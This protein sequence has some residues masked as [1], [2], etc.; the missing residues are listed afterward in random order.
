MKRFLK[1]FIYLLSIHCSALIITSAL[2]VILFVT[3]H[4]Q[5]STAA[6]ADRNLQITAFIRGVWFDNVIGCYAL[7]L[8]LVVAVITAIFN[9]YKK[10]LFRFYYRVFQYILC[11][12]IPN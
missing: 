7:A 3:L 12:S 11:D 6:L 4:H 1:L 2:R 9:Y 8:P 10:P 5:L